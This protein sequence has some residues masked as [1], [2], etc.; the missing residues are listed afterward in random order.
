MWDYGRLAE[1]AR[2]DERLV[3]RVMKAI[4]VDVVRDAEVWP[5]EAGPAAALRAAPV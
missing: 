2:C 5:D 4:C 1:E 3:K